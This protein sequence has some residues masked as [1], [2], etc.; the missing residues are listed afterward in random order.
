M[1]TF[2]NFYES[3]Q[4]LSFQRLQKKVNIL[5]VYYNF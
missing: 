3:P 1:Q 2:S 5:Y 4:N